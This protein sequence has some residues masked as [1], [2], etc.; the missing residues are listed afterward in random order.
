MLAALEPAALALSLEAA[1]HVE[2]ERAAVTRVWHQRLERALYEADR[3]A[4]WIGR[5]PRHS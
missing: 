1:Q 3:A 4:R 2:R 5:I